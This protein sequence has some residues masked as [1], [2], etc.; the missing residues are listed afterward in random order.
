M[1]ELAPRS[2]SSLSLLRLC[3]SCLVALWFA[4]HPLSAQ[5]RGVFVPLDHPAHSVAELLVARGALA[6]LNGADRP[7]ALRD[8]RVAVA[9]AVGS[10]TGEIRTLTAADRGRLEWL[11]AILGSATPEGYWAVGLAPEAGVLGATSAFPELLLPQGDSAAGPALRVRAGAEFGPVSLQFEPQRVRNGRARIPVAVARAEW[12]WGWAQWGEVERNWGPPGVTGLLI[13]DIAG[14]RPEMALA[15]GPPVL[16]FEYRLAPLSDGVSSSTGETVAR[17]WAMHRLRWRPSP[18]FEV[19]LWETALSAE[20]GGPDAARAS[21]LTPFYFPFQQGRLNDRNTAMGL[22]VSWLM[23]LGSWV[24][25]Q[26]LVDDIFRDR[27]PTTEP[28]P[29]RYGYALQL[30]G[31]LGERHAWRAY[32]AALTNLALINRRPEDSFLDDGRPLGRLRPDHREAGVLLTTAWGHST[33]RPVWPGPGVVELGVVWRRQ[34]V[35][36]F[37]DPWPV[38]PP[39]S[40]RSP[41]FSA[42]IEREVWSLVAELDWMAGPLTIQSA[43][44]AQYRRSPSAGRGWGWGFE[45]IVEVNW[46]IGVLGWTGTG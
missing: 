32:T 16:R 19:A 5:L 18:E 41:A 31:G 38:L 20:P 25:A 34:G 6:G 43:S 33:A 17:Y 1:P 42:E 14:S 8:L 46:R 44:H 11:R 13:A 10:P 27:D 9:A 45:A 15:L 24:E 35:R 7:F 36:D 26:L 3:G 4:S 30:R 21:P 2:G 39:G 23:P 40:P 37:A 28:Y 12:R 22:D 29:Q